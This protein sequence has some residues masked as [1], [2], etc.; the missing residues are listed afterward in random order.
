M[1]NIGSQSRPGFRAGDEVFLASGTYQGT[2]GVFL[3]F[4]KDANWANIRE[5][6]GSVRSHPVA[7]LAEAAAGPG[8]ARP[9]Q[10]VI[11]K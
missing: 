8:E 1:N 5:R 10:A 3:G 11:G 2:A 4:H 6:N 7:W 9:E